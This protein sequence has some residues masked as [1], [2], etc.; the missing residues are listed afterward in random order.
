MNYKM[1]GNLWQLNLFVRIDYDEINKKPTKQKCRPLLGTYN[2][3]GC[4]LTQGL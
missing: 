1:F 2:D 3:K 4:Y